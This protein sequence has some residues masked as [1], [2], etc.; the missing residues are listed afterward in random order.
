MSI[1]SIFLGPIKAN[2]GKDWLSG[3]APAIFWGVT[4]NSF[5]RVFA[6][7]RLSLLALLSKQLKGPLL[8]SPGFLKKIRLP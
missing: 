3:Q 1:S 4:F 7:L 6:L 2:E 5:A 8:C